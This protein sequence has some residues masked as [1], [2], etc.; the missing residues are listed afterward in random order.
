[1]PAVRDL[2]SG[3]RLAC[4]RFIGG[5]DF[6]SRAREHTLRTRVAE[7]KEVAELPASMR[8]SAMIEVMT[9]CRSTVTAVNAAL[10][11]KGLQP[12][13]TRPADNHLNWLN[14]LV[15]HQPA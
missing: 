15:E 8:L 6:L 11:V 10:T 14:R 9:R 5:E 3:C 7:T 13:D 2:I 4:H 12:V 1:M